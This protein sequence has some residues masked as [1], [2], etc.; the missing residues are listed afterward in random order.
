[1]VSDRDPV[2]LTCLAFGFA[3]LFWAILRPWWNFPFSLLGKDVSL[4][5]NYR[6]DHAPMW[7]LTISLVVL[8]TIVPFTL[9][10]A[11]LR[12]LRA[13]QVGLVGMVE[14]VA[15]TVIAYVWLAETLGPAQ[16][17]GGAIVIT[18]VVLA[19]TARA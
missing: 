2:S 5:G 13:R 12:H 6:H 16:I 9:S 19:E 17:I 15:A 8:G 4:L 18:G 3:T 10:I 7:V 11:S 1:M 14:P